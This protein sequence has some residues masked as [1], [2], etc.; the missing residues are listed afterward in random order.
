MAGRPLIDRLR[1]VLEP[2]LPVWLS[3]NE[4][5][6]FA[7]SGLPVLPDL[8][9]DA[10]PL[11]GIEAGLLR[12]SPAGLL[13]VAC[14]LP[15]VS[16]RLVGELLER[17]DARGLLVADGAAKSPPLLG[18]WPASALSV[19]QARLERGERSVRGA[20]AALKIPVWRLAPEHQQQCFNLNTPADWEEA[21]NRAGMG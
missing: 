3:A 14:D 13:V 17:A 7:G 6:P 20:L 2:W 9:P 18:V 16:E 12:A 5:A 4:P 10:G 8:R 1:K 15:F 11:A 21:E 19:L